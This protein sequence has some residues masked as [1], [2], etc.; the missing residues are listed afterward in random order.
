MSIETVQFVEM[1]R[2]AAAQLAG[3]VTAYCETCQART[4]HV[5]NVIGGERVRTCL[6]C[7]AQSWEP[8][9]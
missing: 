8:V 5:Q 2:E 1:V 4:E 9:K 7:G 6:D 3:V